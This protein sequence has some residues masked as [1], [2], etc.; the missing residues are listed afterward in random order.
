VEKPVMVEKVAECPLP[1]FPAPEAAIEA[2]VCQVGDTELACLE[3]KSVWALERWIS[4]M[5]RWQEL[6]AACPGVI[7][8][9]SAVTEALDACSKAGDC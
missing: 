6:A 1:P 2:R 7:V 3:A 9:P 4:A 5:V 8:G